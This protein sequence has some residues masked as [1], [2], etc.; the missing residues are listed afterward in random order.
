[1]SESLNE[2]SLENTETRNQIEVFENNKPGTVLAMIR[3]F[4]FDTLSNYKFSIQ[5]VINSQDD[6]SMFQIRSTDKSSRE[7]ELITTSS[8]D[9]ET[10]QY[11]KLKIT[12]YDLQSLNEIDSNDTIMIRKPFR[13]YSES[14]SNNFQINLIEKIKILD[15]NDNGPKFVKSFY[16]FELKE[17]SF[18]LALNQRHAIKA[19]DFDASDLNSKMTYSIIV[20]SN[21]TYGSVLDHIYVNDTL[22]NSY[23]VLMVSRPFDYETE[24]RR[25]EFFL[26]V[27]DINNLTD[28]A[29]VSIKL[30]DQNDNHPVFMNENSTFFIREN[31]PPNS[32]IGQAIAIDKDSQ[33]S[34]SDISFRIVSNAYASLFKIY[35]SG[36]ISNK[37]SLD[38]EQQ[39]FYSIE[40]EAYDFGEPSLT[41]T[42]YYYIQ[43]EDDNDNK[44]I[45]IY[46]NESTNHLFVKTP[47]IWNSSKQM[48]MNIEAMDLD[49]DLNSQLK[50]FIGEQTDELLEIDSSNGS[51]YL[52]LIKLNKTN[53]LKRIIHTKFLIKDSGSPAQETALNFTFFV[54]YERSE[55]PPD[56]FNSNKLFT[57]Y[58]DSRL[59]EKLFKI[60][61]NN[62]ILLAF[63][64][65]TLILIMISSLI[66]IVLWKRSIR[67]KP[68]KRKYKKSRDCK[69][70]FEKF[71]LKTKNR[72]EKCFEQADEKI[73]AENSLTVS[74]KYRTSHF[75]RS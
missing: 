52:D 29:L 9:A 75:I 36:V 19:F 40:I 63:V 68:N 13:F 67:R 73:K 62:Y 35:K 65:A 25:I 66:L 26:A 48:L 39:G 47:T 32:F 43:I 55:L 56:Y 6:T 8:F 72:F 69:C 22:G 58:N 20:K 12:L 1:M 57:F 17:N 28:T 2:F 24:G 38:R 7:F 59:K 33:G 44:P 18:N 11:Y 21:L 10:V 27:Y 5:S 61:S 42:A 23:P 37:V 54:N 45:L 31:M 46:P 50:Y 60:I 74:E 14:N 34:N 53:G 3:V 41:R 30:L 71:L 70:N 64:I 16:E 4:D 51:V 49:Y 15:L